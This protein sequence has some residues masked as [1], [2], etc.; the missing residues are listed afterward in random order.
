M[1]HEPSVS[2]VPVRAFSFP[3]L[4]PSDS[5]QYGSVQSGIGYGRFVS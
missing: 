3:L 1:K 5:Q 4:E 2:R